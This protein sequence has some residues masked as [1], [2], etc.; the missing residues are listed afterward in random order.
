MV[1]LEYLK[2][3]YEKTRQMPGKWPLSSCRYKF[4]ITHFQP[5]LQALKEKRLIGLKCRSCNTVSF[6]PKIVCGKCLVKPDQWVALRDTGIVATFTANYMKDETTGEM[7]SFPV[8][9]IRQDGADTTFLAQLS[10]EV[11]FEDVYVGM[12][13]KVKWKDT[14]E[15]NLGDIECY[16]AV[17]DETKKMKL[18]TE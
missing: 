1:K 16:D 9:A 11:Q 18:Q 3:E 13:V 7:R 4:N 15:G 2:K 10:P 14:P 5:F 6:P 17:E 12:P 8:I